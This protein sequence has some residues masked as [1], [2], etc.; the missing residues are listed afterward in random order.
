MDVPCARTCLLQGRSRRSRR[1]TTGTWRS[2]TPCATA[3]STA[4]S[5]TCATVRARRRAV[6]ATCR[7]SSCSARSSATT[8]STSAS[9]RRARG[10][11]RRSAWTS[12]RSIEHEE[13][14]GL[15]NGGLGRLAACFMDSLATLEMPGDRLRHPLRVRHLRPG[16]PRRLAG[17]GA[18]TSWLQLRQPVGGRAPEHRR[19]RRLR[20]PHRARG[21]TSAAIVRVRWIPERV[22]TAC[23]T[24]RRCSATRRTREHAAPVEGRG[25]RG[26]RLPGRSTSA[27][28]RRRRRR[29]SPPRTSPR[30]S[31][32]TTSPPPASSSASSSSTS[33]SSARCRTCCACSTCRRT[34]IDDVRREVRRPAQRHA[35]GDR[36]RRADAPARRRARAR[37]GPG[38]GHHA[39]DVRVHEPHAAARGARDA[40]RCRCSRGLLPRHLEIIYEINRALP[41]R[42]AAALPGRRGARRAHVAD[43]RERRRAR[44][45]GA[46]RDASAATRST[47]SRA[48]HTE[49]LAQTCCATSPSCGR[50]KFTNVTN[51]VTPRRFL[52]LA[53]P[54]LAALLTDAPIGDG[55]LTDLERLREL[56]TRRGRRG[57]PR[58]VA[59][60]QA[61]EQGALADCIAATHR[62]RSSI[63]PS[64]FDVQCK[65]I[66]EYKRQHLNV[67]HV[68]ALYQRL[69]RGP[70]AR[71]GA[72][73][74]SS[75]PARP[76]P[77]IAWR[78]SIIRLITASPRS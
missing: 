37:V 60:G 44:A 40:G 62:R 19:R 11:A 54:R 65:R 26:V 70:S 59:R 75:S 41:R 3:C 6:A 46:P 4:G 17:R 58:A 25:A 35:P 31:I 50:S 64:L 32:R 51:G 73:H 34:P 14:P 71:R 57:V 29:R 18:P 52:A 49:L 5:R 13:E 42:G 68:I 39:P 63:R 55:W 69:R 12:T 21:P 76:R 61:R 7:P 47:A 77:A 27:T 67:L 66:H 45:H 38:L 53:N 36:R 2:P 9:S 28:T 20:R 30:C 23:R 56:E 10:D 33:S 74:A 1:R 48:L 8:C 22:V 24:T 72:A 16:D 78:S 43:R 15:G